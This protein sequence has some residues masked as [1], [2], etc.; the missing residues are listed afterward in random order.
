[1]TVICEFVQN[2]DMI[3]ATALS[4]YLNHED[5]ECK[6]AW[7]IDHGQDPY[8]DDD[9]D[10]DD[11]DDY[12]E[13]RR[14]WHEDRLRNVMWMLQNLFHNDIIRVYRVITAPVT[15]KPDTQH[16]GIYWSWDKNAAEAH[17][18]DFGIGNVQWEMTADVRFD[19][20]D[21]PITLVQNAMSDYESEREIRLFSDAAVPLVSVKM[22]THA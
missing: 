8:G 5:A 20:I 9:D 1:M 21:W 2:E 10:S 11:D 3:I 14:E 16:P 6:M 17:W 13:F 7:R 12:S 19:Q 22:K 18:G 4:I 15:W